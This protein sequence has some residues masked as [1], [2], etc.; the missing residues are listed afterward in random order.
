MGTVYRQIASKIGKYEKSVHL[1]GLED[2]DDVIKAAAGHGQ[3][4]GGL[5]EQ[6]ERRAGLR[7][8]EAR[9]K[10]LAQ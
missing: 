4:Y 5:V 7:P 10:L 6:D 9:L 2:I 8:A 3:L 1:D